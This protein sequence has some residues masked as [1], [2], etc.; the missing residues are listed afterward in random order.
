MAGHDDI[1]AAKI[2]ARH[3]LTKLAIFSSLGPFPDFA[4]H[5]RLH[6]MI[7]WASDRFME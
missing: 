6:P 4:E 5:L 2:I 7:F 1:H 3:L